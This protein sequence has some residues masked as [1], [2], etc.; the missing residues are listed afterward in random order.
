MKKNVLF[1]LL[2]TVLISACEKDDFCIKNP[3]TPN[4][5]LRFYDTNDRETLKDV[6]RLSIWAENKDTITNYKSINIDSVAIPLNSLATKTIYHLKMNNSDGSIT[7][8]QTATFTITYTTQEEYVSRSC[9]FKI[10]FNDVTFESDNT[11]ITEFT[12]EILTTIDNQ[13]AAHV[14]IFH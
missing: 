4:L 2:L 1:I 7:N 8:N 9:G 11:W 10:L 13:N 12:P 3:V 6:E 14:Q 5:V